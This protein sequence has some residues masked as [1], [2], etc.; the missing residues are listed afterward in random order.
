[1]TT[2]SSTV[3]DLPLVERAFLALKVAVREA[4][5]RHAKAGNPVFVSRNGVITEVSPDEL[6]KRYLV[7]RE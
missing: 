1:M 5:E 6:R 2:P 3:L 7:T 4:L